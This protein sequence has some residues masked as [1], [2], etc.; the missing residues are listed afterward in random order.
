[1]KAKLELNDWS[2]NA[3]LIGFLRIMEKY[4]KD[5]LVVQDNYVEFDTEIL[6]EFHKYYFQYLFET[7]DI[8]KTM[9]KR[10]D[11]SFD[12][13]QQYLEIESEDKKELNDAKEKL[14]R[15][16]KYIKDN[17]KKQL[18]K[19]K[20]FDQETANEIQ[21]E[22]NK[23]DSIKEK[24]QLEEL[25]NIFNQI[26]QCLYKESINKKLTANLFKSILSN[27]YFGQPSFLNVVKNSASY[28]EQMNLM[29]KDYVCLLYTSDAADEL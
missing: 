14:K 17:I 9:N 25:G 7:Y 13:I 20:K 6:K 4:Q 22:Y 28:E 8:A 5:A 21:E 29:Y 10:M 2:Y 26:R 18:D 23:I 1:M 11:E 15:E 27:K 19:I 16:K 3:G 12:R 24:E